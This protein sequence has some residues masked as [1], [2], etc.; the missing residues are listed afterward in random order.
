MGRV[1]GSQ[2]AVSGGRVL[3]PLLVMIANGWKWAGLRY[4]ISTAAE[5][6]CSEELLKKIFDPS[7]LN[8]RS[9]PR[10]RPLEL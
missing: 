4:Y 2:R 10:T 1:V 9:A 3:R 6:G 7:A 5:L 8:P